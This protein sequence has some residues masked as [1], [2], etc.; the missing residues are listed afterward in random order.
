MKFS[1]NFIFIYYYLALSSLKIKIVVPDGI[2]PA[3]GLLL[4][5][6]IFHFKTYK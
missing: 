4:L 3:Y 2:L 5:L 6:R 1:P